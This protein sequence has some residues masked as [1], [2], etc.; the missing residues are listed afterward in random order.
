MPGA[1]AGP[2][3]TTSTSTSSPVRTRHSTT[4]AIEPYDS[5]LREGDS[6]FASYASGGLDA[7]ADLQTSPSHRGHGDLGDIQTVI[8]SKRDSKG[9]GKGKARE[10]EYAHVADDVRIPVQVDNQTETAADP[11]ADDEEAEERRIQENLAKW[12]KADAERRAALRRSS[13]L[14]SSTV[15]PPP[16]IPGAS[17]LIRRT[18]TLLRSASQRRRISGGG[19]GGG[20]RRGGPVSGGLTEEE[21]EL[22]AA[23]Q[24][25][26]PVLR[27]LNPAAGRASADIEDVASRRDRRKMSLRLDSDVDLTSSSQQEQDP[28]LQSASTAR[29]NFSLP[30]VGED[31]LGEDD[32]EDALRTPTTENPS[33]HHASGNPFSAPSQVSLASTGTTASAND[34]QTT[35]RHT[36]GGSVFI[37]NLPPLPKSPAAEE[38]RQNPFASPHTSPDKGSSSQRGSLMHGST[39]LRPIQSSS[40]FASRDPDNPF[41]DVVVTSPSPAKPNASSFR[42]GPGSISQQS[43]VSLPS[44]PH[45]PT[46]GARYSPPDPSSAG[47]ISA[48]S[49]SYRP[50]SPA[51]SASSNPASPLQGGGGS[52]PRRRRSYDPRTEE[53]A[54][55]DGRLRRRRE[56]VQGPYTDSQSRQQQQP[57]QQQV[58]WL[59]W[60]F[61]G[62]LRPENEGGANDRDDAQYPQLLT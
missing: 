47:G 27:S 28:A 50:P 31:T 19:G 48:M 54:D 4:H 8:Y 3:S 22:A 20:G 6:S 34:Q 59:S 46:R 23:G 21:L 60:L 53:S 17:D 12:S 44:P 52:G 24:V 37:E 38:N 56:E 7:A 36:R 55:Y 5:P 29:S 14:G 25:H 2:S 40:S 30:R 32:D 51:L 39:A 45:S 41:I 33:R 1:V 13:R 42:S 10:T 35:P 15:V 26:S 58:G 18:S 43:F 9:K 11:D 16:P 57:E 62:C 61:C 49:G